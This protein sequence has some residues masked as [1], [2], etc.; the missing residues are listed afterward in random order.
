MKVWVCVCVSNPAIVRVCVHVLSIQ[1][2]LHIHY[3][4][5]GLCVVCMQTALPE[6][7][8]SRIAGKR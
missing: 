2:D 6:P 3:S 7:V 1:H 4:I 5:G 8:H